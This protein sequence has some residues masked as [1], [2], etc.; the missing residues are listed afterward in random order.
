MTD[1]HITVSLPAVPLGESFSEPFKQDPEAEREY[2]TALAAPELLAAL[3]GILS[4]VAGIQ[5]DAKYE[6][7]RAA[8]AKA[9]AK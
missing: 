7:A 2:A 9:T 8:I 6:V 3:Q 4:E 5:K 1:K